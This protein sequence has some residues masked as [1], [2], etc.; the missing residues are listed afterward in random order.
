MPKG[1]SPPTAENKLLYYDDTRGPDE[2]A[3][4]PAWLQ[5]KIKNQI[6]PEYPLPSE[7]HAGAS[8]DDEIPF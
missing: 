2:L 6:T 4:L 3:A 1:V 8:F 5:E 7:S